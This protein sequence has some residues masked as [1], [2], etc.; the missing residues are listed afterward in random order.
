MA[1]DKFFIA[2]F[3]Q[4]SGIKRNVKPWL[5]P[6]SAYQSLNN[7]YVF[8]GRVRKRFGYRWMANT[9]LGSRLAVAL[10]GLTDAGTGNY[11]NYIP[12]SGAKIPYAQGAIG[13]MFSV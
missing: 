12:Y 9:Q 7:S 3:D 13:Q 6:D 11:D 8:R 10:P 2:P 4:E 1:I 5:I